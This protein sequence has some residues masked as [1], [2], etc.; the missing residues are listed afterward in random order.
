LERKS[1]GGFRNLTEAALVVARVTEKARPKPRLLAAL[2]AAAAAGG[3]LGGQSF[4]LCLGA[5]EP[6][7]LQFPEYPRMLD[8][9]P[10]AVDQALGIFS[11]SWSHVCHLVVLSSFDECI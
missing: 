6:A 1:K 8:G 7:V 2:L 3:P 11:L 10:E 9:R 5:E 4:L